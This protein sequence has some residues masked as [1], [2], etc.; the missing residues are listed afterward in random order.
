[1]PATEPVPASFRYDAGHAMRQ[2]ELPRSGNRDTS[3]GCLDGGNS[4]DILGTRIAPRS[5]STSRGCPLGGSGSCRSA[6]SQ[7]LFDAR[8]GDCSGYTAATTVVYA[9]GY[10][11]PTVVWSRECTVSGAGA[12]HSGGYRARA[13]LGS[14]RSTASASSKMIKS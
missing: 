7:N 12:G 10:V 8:L 9:R 11:P 14:N 6:L 4:D 1:M 2:P 3:A 5:E 13:H